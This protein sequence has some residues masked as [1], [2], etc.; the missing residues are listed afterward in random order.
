MQKLCENCGERFIASVKNASYC[1]R[2]CKAEKGRKECGNLS[3]YPGV[4][5]GTVGA[6]AELLVSA[7][8]MA[9]K[10]H[11][12]RALSPSCPCD[13]IAMKDGTMKRIEVRTAYRNSANVVTYGKQNFAAD[14]WALCLPG[15]II[16]DP[17]L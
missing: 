13:L 4:A 6:L 12:F 16:Y 8:L 11:V 14:H 15:T 9:K 2:K 7:D 10:Y 17:P 3:N 1:S 5:P